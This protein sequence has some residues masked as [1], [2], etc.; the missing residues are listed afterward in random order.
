M[1]LPSL[2]FFLEIS[3]SQQFVFYFFL[4]NSSSGSLFIATA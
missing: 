2:I 1:I 3:P 4:I